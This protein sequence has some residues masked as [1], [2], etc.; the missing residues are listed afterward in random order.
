VYYVRAAHAADADR[1]AG[2][3]VQACVS[4]IS[5][6]RLRV[7]RRDYVRAAHAADADRFAGR[8]AQA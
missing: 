3:Y 8:Y 5:S 7:G 6:H 4:I 2:R 1:F